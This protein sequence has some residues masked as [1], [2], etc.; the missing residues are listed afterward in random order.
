MA[1]DHGPDCHSRQFLLSPIGIWDL[2]ISAAEGSSVLADP[3][4]LSFIGLN[5]PSGVAVD[6]C[7]DVCVTDEVNNEVLKRPP[8]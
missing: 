5:T 4:T 7:A 6:A 8:R 2:V 3:T 1:T